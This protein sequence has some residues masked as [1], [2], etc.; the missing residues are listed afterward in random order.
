M[1]TGEFEMAERVLTYV[2]QQQLNYVDF[3]TKHPFLE[4]TILNLAIVFR[5]Q[6]KFT[7]A[8]QMFK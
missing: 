3:N 1:G 8:S 5:N 7:S 4:Q 6:E 2:F